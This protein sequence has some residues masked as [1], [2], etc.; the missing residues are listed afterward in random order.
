MRAK[1]SQ[2]IKSY[3]YCTKIAIFIC[4]LFRRIVWYIYAAT[5][6]ART[7]IS[8]TFGLMTCLHTRPLWNVTAAAHIHC[9]DAFAC[10]VF[11]SCPSLPFP[12]RR[13][14]GAKV[15]GFSQS[16]NIN[17]L[18]C[19]FSA[20]VHFCLVLFSRFFFCL[21]RL[22]LFFSL[23][24]KHFTYSNCYGVG[25]SFSLNFSS[26]PI[27]TLGKLLRRGELVGENY[28]KINKSF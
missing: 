14:P 7:L 8:F 18:L 12:V 22:L 20:R 15:F 23:K 9:D 26:T 2:K 13:E 24:H 11:S 1:N 5:A 25:Q 4:F 21:E 28:T 3:L 10:L 27:E 16:I 17:N 6:L 19:F